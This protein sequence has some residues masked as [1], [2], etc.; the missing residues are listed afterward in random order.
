VSVLMHLQWESC[1]RETITRS[2]SILQYLGLPESTAGW[3][4]WF[5]LH[6]HL[7]ELRYFSY[8]CGVWSI[9]TF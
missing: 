9:V 3:V 5:T 8:R 1:L 4:I 7:S 2:N 6:M